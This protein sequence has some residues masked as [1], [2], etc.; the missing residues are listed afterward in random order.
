MQNKYFFCSYA[1]IYICDQKKETV[2]LRQS[3]I[4]IEKKELFP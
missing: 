1:N 4:V 3:L 2:I